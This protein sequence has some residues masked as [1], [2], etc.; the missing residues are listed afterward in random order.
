MACLKQSKYASTADSPVKEV[1][2][3]PN[4]LNKRWIKSLF[5]NF[6][7]NFDGAPGNVSLSADTGA[8][9]RHFNGECITSFCRVDSMLFSSYARS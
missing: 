1:L 5:G 6:K 8:V 3:P 2:L 9:I 7:L 4:N